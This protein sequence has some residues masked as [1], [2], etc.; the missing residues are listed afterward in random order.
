MPPPYVAPAVSLAGLELQ[1][2]LGAFQQV[3]ALQALTTAANTNANASLEV[4]QAV[5]AVPG[6]IAPADAARI[7]ELIQE[8]NTGEAFQ[9]LVVY[10][11]VLQ[12]AH[13]EC[14]TGL[15]AA[16]TLPLER[17]AALFGVGS[18][19]FTAGFFGPA[20]G[21]RA[22][23]LASPLRPDMAP[24]L[25]LDFEG[26]SQTVT[27][28]PDPTSGGRRIFLRLGREGTAGVVLPQPSVSAKH[29]EISFF[30]GHYWVQDQGSLNGTWINGVR[31]AAH[32]QRVL[33]DGD[34][35]DLGRVVFTVRLP[36]ERQLRAFAGRLAEAGTFAQVLAFLEAEGFPE[37]AAKL[38]DILSTRLP[39]P[40]RLRRLRG[41]IP[42]DGGLL[43]K[44]EAILLRGE[45]VRLRSLYFPKMTPQQALETGTRLAAS[46]AQARSFADLADRLS[47]TNAEGFGDWIADIEK[48]QRFFQ[49]EPVDDLRLDSFPDTFG[50]KAQV[51]RLFMEGLSLDSEQRQ[52][53]QRRGVTPDLLLERPWRKIT[54]SPA[55]KEAL[56]PF[57][58]AIGERLNL[59]DMESTIAGSFGDENDSPAAP[60]DEASA[61]EPSGKATAYILY[62]KYVNEQPATGPTATQTGSGKA[63]FFD[64]ALAK[65]HGDRIPVRS[66]GYWF[67][68]G[69]YAPEERFEGRVYLSLR[70]RH[71]EAIYR[72]LH[73]EVQS[74]I[75]A[76]GGEIQFKVAGIPDG[77]DRSDSG[78][79]YFHAKNQEA[80]YAALLK[81][82]RA[83]PE[84]FKEGHPHFTI[85]LRD[86]NGA[87]LP[88]LS[89]GEHPGHSGQSFGSQRTEAMT[90][91]VR[92]ARALMGTS[93]PPDWEEIQQICAYFLKRAGVDIENPS[94]E[95]GGRAKFGPL[96]ARCGAAKSPPPAS[97]SPAITFRISGDARV[98]EENRDLVGTIPGL[99]REM[100][101]ILKSGVQL[102]NFGDGYRLVKTK[103]G[104]TMMGGMAL[105]DAQL[106][107]VRAWQ[108]RLGFADLE[109]R[110]SDSPSHRRLAE[111]AAEKGIEFRGGIS[112]G[113]AAY[114]HDLLS[115]LPDSF[116]KTGYLKEIHIG[117]RRLSGGR[118]GGYLKGAVSVTPFFSYGSRRNLMGFLLHETGHST[119]VRYAVSAD[120]NLHQFPP[121]KTI[122]LAVRRRMHEDVALVTKGGH[123]FALDWLGGREDRRGYASSFSE[124]TAEFHLH[125][126]VAGDQLRAHIA[127]LPEG[128]VKDAYQRIYIEFSQR[129]FDRIEYS[130][131]EPLATRRVPPPLP[132]RA[133]AV[134]PPLPAP[135]PK[136]ATPPP[137]APARV[138]AGQMK[139]AIGLEILSRYPGLA[140]PQASTL[141]AAIAKGMYGAWEQSGRFPGSSPEAPSSLPEDIFESRMRDVVDRLE[142]DRTSPVVEGFWQAIVTGDQGPR[143]LRRIT[144]RLK[145]GSPAL[146]EPGSEKLRNILTRHI[147]KAWTEGDLSDASLEAVFREKVEQVIRRIEESGKQD[148]FS[149]RLVS[150]LRHLLSS[151]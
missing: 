135:A 59:Q 147:H 122:P 10:Q 47:R 115:R 102:M 58:A 51:N 130:F 23:S 61:R 110:E 31:L 140:T 150:E 90:A 127:S 4:L 36:Y 144:T 72:Y 118:G 11:A 53:L 80:V 138:N 98:F 65:M 146:S 45:V 57:H 46:L 74:A 17:I 63:G 39:M 96:L 131:G 22:W 92:T 126:V 37:T 106:A 1:S 117:G 116:L 12:V 48:L 93:E 120:E 43:L 41:E 97:E 151:E 85:P 104:E 89:F 8:G 87:V 94:F 105:N 108:E 82:S 64:R 133:R 42:Y 18:H 3:Q 137:V 20:E 25:E 56:K 15:P 114:I 129:V 21:S 38:R 14:L 69:S 49:G 5:E 142:R 149:L 13:Q 54:V 100:H 7:R 77:Y 60:A 16:S 81:M 68:G 6:V 44:V 2:A 66:D 88:G 30:N 33:K 75:T 91:A 121:D 109:S 145:K 73:D 35:V 70:R 50:L 32:E 132:V 55:L 62:E 71:V 136:P 67:F 143:V 52:D 29:A 103:G 40:E 86:E 34:R 101:E 141:V 83:H 148:P 107:A 84:F 113:Q 134:P 112:P 139:S 119:D 125:Y 79:V 19:D 95:E 76:N 123:G 28:A 26:G 111:W 24:R 124:F 128:P 99:T 9:R 78:V 27:L